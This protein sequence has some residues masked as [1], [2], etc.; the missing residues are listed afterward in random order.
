MKESDHPPFWLARG[1][2]GKR[3]INEMRMNRYTFLLALLISIT[4]V[5]AE[6]QIRLKNG[7]VLKGQAVKFDEG[8]MTLTFKFAQGTL[9]YPSADLA[10]VRLE[11]RPGVAEGRD[12][13]TKGNWEEVVTRWKPSVDTLVGVDCPWV[14]ECAGG[15]GQAYL[16]LG[17]VADAETLFGK[18]KK[19][20]TQGP[21]ALRASVGL[22]EATSS[23][24]AGALLEKLKEM[25]GQLKESLRPM[26]ADREA[27]AE[28]YFVRGGAYEKKGDAKKALEDFVRVGALYPDPPSLGQRADQKAEALRMAN[29][30]LVTD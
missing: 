9:G 5:G 16:A 13:Y 26:R 4:L 22:A 25:E 23:R 14:L 8:S 28:F 18:M 19:F 29:K 2:G 24:D 11:E 17:K 6:D 12:A 27:L 21:A 3:K 15:L 30:D 1:G 10:E 7:E 20:Y